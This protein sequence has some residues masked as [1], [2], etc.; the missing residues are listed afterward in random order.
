MV[1]VCVRSLFLLDPEPIIALPWQSVLYLF[2]KIA[3][4][5]K[6]EVCTKLSKFLYVNV[7]LVMCTFV[8]LRTICYLYSMSS[9]QPNKLRHILKFISH[10]FFVP[11]GS[12]GRRT[13]FSRKPWIPNTKSA[14]SCIRGYY[15]YMGKNK[16]FEIQWV[17]YLIPFHWPR[18]AQN[19]FC[20][21]DCMSGRPSPAF[22]WLQWEFQWENDQNQ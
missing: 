16:K 3:K 11:A 4:P 1:F 15:Q 18:E 8:C 5:N 6:A 12:V 21:W 14:V 13:W 2:A 7:K 17:P 9:F 20:F 10:V 22:F 19:S